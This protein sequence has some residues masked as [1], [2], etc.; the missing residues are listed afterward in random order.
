MKNPAK[1]ANNKPKGKIPSDRIVNQGRHEARCLICAHQDREQ[2]EQSFVAWV[3]PAKIAEEHSVSR[4][5]VYRHA[6]AM[7]LM[8]K[9]RRNVRAALERIIEKAGEVEVNASSVVGAVSAYARINSRGE[10]VERAETVNVNELFQRMT[11]SEL[12]AYAKAGTLPDW[13]Q[14]PSGAT[15]TDSNGGKDVS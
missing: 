14:G 11:S 7:G 13:F 5:G 4:D 2:I 9:R 6:H 1:V 3:S 15:P 10:W 12:E 8:E